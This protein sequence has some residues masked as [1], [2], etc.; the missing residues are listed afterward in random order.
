MHLEEFRG[1][2]PRLNADRYNVPT[3]VKSRQPRPSIF[4]P[5]SGGSSEP[6]QQTI[7][8]VSADTLELQE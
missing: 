1:K 5:Y 4:A 6:E 7:P 2:K 3:E 8:P